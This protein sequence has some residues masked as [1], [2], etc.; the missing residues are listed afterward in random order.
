MVENWRGLIPGGVIVTPGNSVE[1]DTGSWRTQRPVIDFSRCTH[2]MLCWIYCPDSCFQVSPERRLV[3][4]DYAHCKG[5]AICAVQCPP[6]CIAMV[7]ELTF[8]E[9]G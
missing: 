2:C 1:Y 8:Q 6:K 9:E 5:C 4:L 3:G 7:D